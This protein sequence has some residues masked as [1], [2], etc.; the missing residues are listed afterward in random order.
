MR[1]FDN[2]QNL[3]L[4]VTLLSAIAGAALT[5]YLT[6]ERRP[7]LLIVTVLVAIVVAFLLKAS[8]RAEA[9]AERRIREEHPELFERIG[10]DVRKQ[11]ERHNASAA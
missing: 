8:A 11:L 6:K 4:A 2:S 1:K 3:S 9:E 7:E 10:K 5:A